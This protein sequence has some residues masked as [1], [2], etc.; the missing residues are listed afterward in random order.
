MVGLSEKVKQGKLERESREMNVG[1]CFRSVLAWST[2][3]LPSDCSVSSLNDDM[4]DE[5]LRFVTL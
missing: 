5:V 1:C 2:L 3:P 4:Y